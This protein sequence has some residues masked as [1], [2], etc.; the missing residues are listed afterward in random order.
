MQAAKP[1]RLVKDVDYYMEG[2]KL[3]FTAAYHRK[4]GFCC[5][6]KCRHC[7][8]RKDVAPSAAIE[9]VGLSLATGATPVPSKRSG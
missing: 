9:L 1:P 8:Y 7:P 2:E 5:N 3:V 4:R 6:S